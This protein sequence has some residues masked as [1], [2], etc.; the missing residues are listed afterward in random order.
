MQAHPSKAT[1]GCRVTFWQVS[2]NFRE[3]RQDTA[4]P[5]PNAKGS[6]VQI[7]SARRM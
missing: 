3:K 1:H 6:Q 7:L 4:D 5:L 2:T